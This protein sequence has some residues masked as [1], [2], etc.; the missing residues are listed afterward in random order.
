ME[1]PTRIVVVI[2][3]GMIQSVSRVGEAPV[4]VVFIDYDVEGDPV[5]PTPI[6]QRNADPADA[7]VSR[8]PASEVSELEAPIRALLD[9]MFGTGAE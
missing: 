1:T 8:W 5:D 3:G 6:P 2:E 7:M 9:S 4:D